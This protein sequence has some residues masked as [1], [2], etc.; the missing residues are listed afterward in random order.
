MFNY[1]FLQISD[2]GYNEIMSKLEKIKH[3]EF[4]SMEKALITEQ[5]DSR[6]VNSE[7]NPLIQKLGSRAMITVDGPFMFNPGPFQRWFMGAV[8]T[9]EIMEAVEEAHN[10]DEIEYG[11]CSSCRFKLKLH[12]AKQILNCALNEIHSVLGVEN[13]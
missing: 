10:D 6:T 2:F 9:Q 13:K 3:I 4:L 12:S 5:R 8:D 7:G 11:I 1:Q